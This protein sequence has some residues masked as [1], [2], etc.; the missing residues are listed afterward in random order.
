MLLSTVISQS[1]PSILKHLSGILSVAA[2]S[3]YALLY[4]LSPA[5]S[6]PDGHLSDLVT[7]LTSV[8]HSVGCLSPGLPLKS[9]EATTTVSLAFFERNNSMLFRSTLPGRQPT[10]VGRWHSNRVQRDSNDGR[11]SPERNLKEIHGAGLYGLPLNSRTLRYV[12]I[13]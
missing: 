4:V 9:R 11:R 2:S 13:V 7:T 6:L 8:P 12:R 3:Q 1:T 10:S 5:P